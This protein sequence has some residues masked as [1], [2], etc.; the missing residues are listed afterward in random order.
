M[1]GIICDKKK[2]EE[3]LGAEESEE[4]FT[5]MTSEAIKQQQ[6]KQKW[7][8]DLRKKNHNK[9]KHEDEDEGIM[10]ELFV[11]IEKNRNHFTIHLH[12]AQS[13]VTLSAIQDPD[14]LMS[15][16]L[17]DGC[18]EFLVLAEEKHLEFSTLRRAKFSLMVLLYELHMKEQE[19]FIYTCNMCSVIVEMRYHCNIC[20]DYDLCLKCFSQNDHHHKMEKQEFDHDGSDFGNMFNQNCENLITR[21]IQNPAQAGVNKIFSSINDHSYR[22]AGDGAVCDMC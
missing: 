5:E 6:K 11:T 14:G 4:E 16:D 17:M 9:I 2:E 19:R 8:A 22:H 15:C 13:A 18:D 21:P 10:Q 3:R 1:E 20:D 12:L 7:S